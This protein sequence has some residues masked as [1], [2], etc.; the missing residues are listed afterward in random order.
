MSPAPTTRT[1]V[2]R[3]AERGRYD[4]ALIDAVLDEGLICHVGISRSDGPVVLPM[5]YAR[6][7]DQLYL[8]GARGN[9]LLRSARGCQVCVTVTLLD[10]L[11]LARAAF[12]HSVNYR[13]VVVFGEASEVRDVSEQL[14]ASSALVDHV[15]PGRSAQA[16][17]PSAQELRRT[18]ILRLPIAEASAK[19]R[20]GAPV[21]EPHDLGLG[22]WAGE[23]PLSLA[24]GRPIPGPDL[25]AG[26]EVPRYVTD[27]RRPAP[28]ARGRS[29]GHGPRGTVAR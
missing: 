12:H 19:V 26:L 11:V 8:H 4:R 21:D 25:E 29:G 15:V 20:T 23:L 18:L 13:S 9:A 27:Y 28:T 24:I 22:V 16:R 14:A 6:L 5:V 1:Q 10:G 2:R 7:G 3:A 17:V